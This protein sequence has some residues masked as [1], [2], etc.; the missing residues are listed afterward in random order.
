M[1]ISTSIY[2]GVLFQQGTLTI[3]WI[4][5]SQ[6]TLYMNIKTGTSLH[7]L[8]GLTQ[9]LKLSLTLYKSRIAS[10]TAAVVYHL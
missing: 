1:S 3:L 2:P 10:T 8:S 9:A 4:F 6:K 5:N 7:R